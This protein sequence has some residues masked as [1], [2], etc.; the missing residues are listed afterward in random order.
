MRTT[1]VKAYAKIN[2]TLEVESK[3]PDGYHTLNT[4][5][6]A[7]SL[8]DHIK[9]AV[10]EQGGISLSCNLNY[11]PCDERNI[12]HK[13]A[14]QFYNAIGKTEYGLEIDMEKR[15]PVGAGLAGGSADCG[16]VLLALNRLEGYPLSK[17]QLYELG[18]KLGSDVPFTMMGGCAVAYGL[19]YDLTPIAPMPN[20]YLVL[21]KPRFSISTKGAFEA[22]T[23]EDYS[24]E[25]HSAK[26][27]ELVESGDIFA[28]AKGLYNSF[29]EPVAKKRPQIHA[30]KAKLL[31]CGAIGTL[32][33]GSG[34]T[35]YGI[36]TN[37]RRAHG[38]QRSMRRLC[39]EVYLTRPMRKE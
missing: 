7:V 11:V 3:R 30:I 17:E 39:Q 13:A 23:P 31:D 16:A 32:M 10:K 28:V 9:I 18:A 26:M 35:V 22:L 2:L 27:V 15:I 8:Y 1:K 20:C 37:S 19:G 38:A 34:S 21:C 25:N 29:E 24:T 5:M 33:S 14:V 4:V 36:F 6:Q 12:V